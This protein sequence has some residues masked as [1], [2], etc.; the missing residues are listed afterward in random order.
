MVM[1]K[2]SE[3]GR[4]MSHVTDWE[5]WA[6]TSPLAGNRSGTRSAVSTWFPATSDPMRPSAESGESQLKPIYYG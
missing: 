6:R 2:R 1:M 4:F 3:W 5:P